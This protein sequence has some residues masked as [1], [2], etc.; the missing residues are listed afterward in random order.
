MGR[1]KQGGNDAPAEE[2]ICAG[3]E[4]VHGWGE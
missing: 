2:A 3:H 1:G 4:D